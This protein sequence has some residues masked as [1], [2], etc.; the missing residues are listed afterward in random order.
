[1]AGC[2]EIAETHADFGEAFA[3]IGEGLTEMGGRHGDF[4][5][6]RPD[7]GESFSDFGETFTDAG[8]KLTDRG[9]PFAYVGKRMNEVASPPF[10]GGARL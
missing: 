8:Q 5:L 10:P 7:V 1:M 4:I 3:W 2:T 6:G 9:S